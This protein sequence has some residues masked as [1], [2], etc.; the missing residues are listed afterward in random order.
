MLNESE[1]YQDAAN[2][3]K[4]GN[5][6]SEILSGLVGVFFSEVLK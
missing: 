2:G 3:L 6:F 1:R 5:I 4:L